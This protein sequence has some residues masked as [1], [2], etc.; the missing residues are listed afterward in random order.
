V[1]SLMVIGAVMAG[2]VATFVAEGAAAPVGD[3]VPP[4]GLVPT[5]EGLTI[6]VALDAPCVVGL[7]A[8]VGILVTIDVAVTMGVGD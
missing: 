6:A 7:A 8:G 1:S 2:G 4:L 5:A 3:G